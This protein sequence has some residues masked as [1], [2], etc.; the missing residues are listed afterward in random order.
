MNNLLKNKFKI[1]DQ[2]NNFNLSLSNKTNVLKIEYI[3]SKTKKINYFK[4]ILKTI[5]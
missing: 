1:F 4:T 3:T 2:S 5:N